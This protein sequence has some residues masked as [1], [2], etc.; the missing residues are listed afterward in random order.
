VR[1]GGRL[2]RCLK[3]YAQKL[4]WADGKGPECSGYLYIQERHPDKKWTG[5]ASTIFSTFSC[6]KYIFRRISKLIPF[7]K[8]EKMCEKSTTEENLH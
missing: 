3:R 1:L 5:M 7:E 4:S 2:A 6:G 8:S